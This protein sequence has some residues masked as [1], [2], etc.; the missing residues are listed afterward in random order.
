[1]IDKYSEKNNIQTDIFQIPDSIIPENDRLFQPNWNN[2]P[3]TQKNIIKTQGKRVL[4]TG[5][6]L[7]I[8]SKAGTGKSSV[9]E[10][11]VANLLNSKC[12]SLGFECDLSENSGRDK[13]LYIDTERTIQDTWSSWERTYRRAKIKAPNI[14]K[15]LLFFNFKAIAISER[16]RMVSEILTKNKDIG[17]VI[18]DGATDFIRDTNSITEASEF[19]DWINTFNPSISIIVTIH[20]NPMDNKPRGHIGSELC[21]RAESLFLIRKLEDGIREITT[22]FEHGKVR[23]DGDCITNYY[24]YSED[25]NMFVSSDYT[26]KEKNARDIEKT[27]ELKNI[28]HDIFNGKTFLSSTKIIDGLSEKLNKTQPASKSIFNRQIRDKIVSKT[29]EGYKLQF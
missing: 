6:M 14:D 8:V 13:V 12:D 23:N 21:R 10:S 5:N 9:C 18:F 19:I 26:P 17:L 4:T 3:P 27:E 7:A 24:E 15:R 20:S 28:L 1:M 11:I 16:K 29:S 2:K 25:V 22:E